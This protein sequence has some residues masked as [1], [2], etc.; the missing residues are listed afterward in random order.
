MKLPVP[1]S[2]RHLH[3]ESTL[4]LG[5]FLHGATHEVTNIDDTSVL[6]R[7]AGMQGNDALAVKPRRETLLEMPDLTSNELERTHLWGQSGCRSTYQEASFPQRV[8][9][10]RPALGR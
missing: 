7:A 4:I 9:T 3:Q 5:D 1:S 8:M 10:S 6:T 2:G